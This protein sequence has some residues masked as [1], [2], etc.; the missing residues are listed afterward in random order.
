[1]VIKCYLLFSDELILVKSLWDFNDTDVQL[2]F[3]VYTVYIK[4]ANA[5]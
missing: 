3:N 2:W 1:M 5:I 4:Q